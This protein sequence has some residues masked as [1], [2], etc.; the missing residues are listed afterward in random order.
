M[1]AVQIT[2]FGG[3]K[4]LDLPD[5]NPG[6]AN[7]STRSAR[8]ESTTPTPTTAASMKSRTVMASTVASLAS[9]SKHAERARTL[10]PLQAQVCAELRLD[11]RDLGV[12]E[13]AALIP[14]GRSRDR[15][16]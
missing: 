13:Q 16:Q 12:R 11:A 9:R 14:Q 7:S 4:V 15:A 6:T 2:R 8:Q 3:P 10:R 5:P 1:R